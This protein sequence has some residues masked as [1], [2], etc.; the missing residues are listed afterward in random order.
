MGGPLT[1]AAGLRGLREE[2][3]LMLPWAPRKF[4]WKRRDLSIGKG[5]ET[6]REGT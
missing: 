3:G 2:W 4:R 1:G 5:K 6:A